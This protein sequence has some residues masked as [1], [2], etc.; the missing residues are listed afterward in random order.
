MGSAW[1]AP[2]AGPNWTTA[3]S[4]S[5]SKGGNW[6]GSVPNAVVAEA[7]INASTTVPLTITVDTPATLG[8]LL[9]GNAGAAATGY[10]LSGT[11]GNTLT[12]N[13]SGNGA[14]IMVT[15]GTHAV[16]L[17]VT[18]NDN[19]T[20]DD[21]GSLTLGGAIAKGGRRAKGITMSGS[22][23]LA[24]GNSNTYSGITLISGGTVTLAHRLAAQNSTVNIGQSGALGF[25]A[26]ITSLLWAV[27][28]GSATWSWRLPPPSPS[29]SAWAATGR[30]R[31]TTAS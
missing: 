15:N 3:V 24:L 30:A 26:G 28:R 16:D 7:V 20:V 18:L 9:L 4:G 6:T 17:P 8:S 23:N 22:G 29:C 12:L 10:T 5:W 13:N 14:T 1:P 25:A 19:V 21:Y 27:S 31:S 11:G 2:S